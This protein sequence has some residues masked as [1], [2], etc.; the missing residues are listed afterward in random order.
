MRLAWNQPTPVEGSTAAPARSRCAR[1]PPATLGWPKVAGG[2][3]PAT[4]RRPGG[5]LKRL[6]LMWEEAIEITPTA[7][8][9]SQAS[10]M[11]RRSGAAEAECA[12]PPALAPTGR[13][14]LEVDI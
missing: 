8:A 13:R 1:R 14:A 4:K 7:R 11:T 9:A 6:A 12:R 2:G 5:V 3:S 10:A